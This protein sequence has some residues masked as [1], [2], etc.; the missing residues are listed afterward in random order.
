MDTE[1]LHTV[2]VNVVSIENGL[3]CIFLQYNI[4]SRNVKLEIQPNQS[5]LLCGATTHISKQTL[6][7]ILY[8]INA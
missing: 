4:R 7:Y 3:D 8:P 2:N 5:V 6:I 1:E